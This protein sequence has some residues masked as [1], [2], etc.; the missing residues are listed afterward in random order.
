[1]HDL[2]A[3]AGIAVFAASLYWLC[4]NAWSEKKHTCICACM[5]RK[6]SGA[7]NDILYIFLATY[8]QQF[9]PIAKCLEARR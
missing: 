2:T 4:M 3:T 8:F 7:K 1:M 5:H 9:R 6:K